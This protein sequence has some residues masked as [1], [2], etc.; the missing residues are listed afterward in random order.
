[1]ATV[2]IVGRSGSVAT[3]P[4]T[5]AIKQCRA[6]VKVDL[7]KRDSMEKYWLLPERE[8]VAVEVAMRELLGYLSDI[9][10]ATDLDGVL[11]EIGALQRALGGE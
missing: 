2:R 7:A 10:H 4:A 11:A 1:M 3:S 5:E 8:D 6:A 9:A